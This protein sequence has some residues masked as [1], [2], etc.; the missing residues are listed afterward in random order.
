M[1]MDDLYTLSDDYVSEDGEKGEDGRKGSL[2]INDEERYVVD[3]EA[4]GQVS[5]SSATLVGVGNDY[6]FMSAVY[7]LLIWSVSYQTVLW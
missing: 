6:N 7:E 4:I 5:D 2:A 3:L 1:S